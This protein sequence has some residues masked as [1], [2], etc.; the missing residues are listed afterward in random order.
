MI[1]ARKQEADASEAAEGLDADVESDRAAAADDA[2]TADDPFAGGTS[3]RLTFG[4]G[5]ES[6][7]VNYAALEQM[8]LTA[9][10][11]AGHPDAAYEISNPEYQSGSIRNFTA[12]DVKFDLPPDQAQAVLDELQ[13]TINS[14][15]VFPL[16]NKI[17]SRVA[18]QMAA[19]AIAATLL[20]CAGLVGFLW[21]RF[22]GV[23]YGIAA[24]FA[25]LFDVIIVIGAVALSAYIVDVAPGFAAAIQLD[26]FKM[27]LTLVAALLTLVGYCINDTIVVFDRIREVKGKSPRLTAEMIN[28]SINQTLSRTLLTGLTTIGSVVVLYI[29]GGEGIHGFAYSLFIGFIVGTFGSI[30]IASPV[31]LWLTHRAEAAGAA[32]GA[33]AAKPSPA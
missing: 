19:Q 17:G 12:W 15:P 3:V 29:V 14:Q 25:L 9:R 32:A 20:C 5:G 8:L 28:A 30:F 2:A 26:K 23:M 4:G 7:G 6:S 1:P 16:S 21:F 27:D 33:K 13:A 22:H 18:S 11:D 31:L 10:A 24:V